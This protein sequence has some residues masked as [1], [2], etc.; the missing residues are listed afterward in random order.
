MDDGRNVPDAAILF[1][2]GIKPVISI[3]VACPPRKFATESFIRFDIHFA[4]PGLRLH[5]RPFQEASR[6]PM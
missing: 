4:A 2:G 3:G 6:L 1:V 5:E